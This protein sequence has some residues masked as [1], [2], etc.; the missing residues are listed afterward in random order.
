MP[1]VLLI[2]AQ[3]H[4]MHNSIIPIQDPD[5]IASEEA[6]NAYF[7]NEESVHI[8]DIK[9]FI[10]EV[11]K[12][13]R[14]LTPPVQSGT[15]TN[16]NNNNDLNNI[17]IK[18]M[19]KAFEHHRQETKKKWSRQKAACVTACATLISSAITLTVFLL[20]HNNKCNN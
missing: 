3:I 1:L 12:E 17:I 8:R 9:P 16:N 6:F 11:I 13:K 5:E 7:R 18:A 10:K 14:E 19:D 4:A 20:S 15:I 2:T